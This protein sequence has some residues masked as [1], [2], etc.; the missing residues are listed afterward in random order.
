MDLFLSQAHTGSD[1]LASYK[2]QRAAAPRPSTR[3]VLGEEGVG[4]PCRI[5]FAHTVSGVA[6]SYFLVNPGAPSDRERMVL[7]SSLPDSFVYN[8]RDAVVTAEAPAWCPFNDLQL[9][10]FI[11]RRLEGAGLTDRSKIVNNPVKAAGEMCA[12]RYSGGSTPQNLVFPVGASEI[13]WI[14]VARGAARLGEVA[15]SAA[16]ATKRVPDLLEAPK[17]LS[18]KEALRRLRTWRSVHWVT[19]AS[20][21]A[22][23][24]RYE[25]FSV[26]CVLYNHEVAR[27]QLKA[28]HERCMVFLGDSFCRES[29]LL[30]DVARGGRASDFWTAA[31]AVVRYKCKHAAS[32][33]GAREGAATG[34]VENWT[35]KMA[36]VRS[37]RGRHPEAAL[38][39]TLEA[40][41]RDMDGI[42]EARREQVLD[43]VKV[44][45]TREQREAVYRGL[46]GR[47]VYPSALN[48]L[49]DS[50]LCGPARA[51]VWVALQA[52]LKQI[53]FTVLHLL[54]YEAQRVLMLKIFVPALMGLFLARGG[55]GG[56]FLNGVFNLECM[57]Q[58]AGGTTIRD[59]LARDSASSFNPVSGLASETGAVDPGQNGSDGHGIGLGLGSCS[60]GGGPPPR[61]YSQYDSASLCGKMGDCES[62][63]LAINVGVPL[64]RA[65]IKMNMVD[66]VVDYTV[67]TGMAK[68]RV[69]A[70]NRAYRRLAARRKRSAE[71]AAGL[72]LL[73][74]HKE[75][76]EDE[77]EDEKD[78]DEEGEQNGKPPAKRPRGSW[79]ERGAAAQ[80]M[81]PPVS[82]CPEPLCGGKAKE[83][84]GQ[85]ALATIH[86]EDRVINVESIQKLL[87]ARYTKKGKGGRYRDEAMAE[88]AIKYI[89]NLLD[90]VFRLREGSILNSIHCNARTGGGIYKAGP[91]PECNCPAAEGCANDCLGAARERDAA[92]AESKKVERPVNMGDAR[93]VAARFRELMM[94]PPSLADLDDAMA[95]EKVLQNEQLLVS[96]DVNPVF[97]AVLGARGGDLGRYVVLT[98]MVKF[99]NVAIA[100][101]V[102]GDIP[103]AVDSKTAVKKSLE[104]GRPRGLRRHTKVPSASGATVAERARNALKSKP[105]NYLEAG[106]CPQPHLKEVLLPD[107]ILKLKSIALQKGRGGRA[108]SRRQK[109]EHGF[110]KMLKYLFF[111]LDPEK[112]AESFMDPASAATLLRLDRICRD[113]KR[114]GTLH[115]YVDLLDPVLLGTREWV[116]EGEYSP[117]GGPDHASPV[118]FYT[119]LKNAMVDEGV[120]KSPAEMSG[121][122]ATD[123]ADT[124]LGSAADLF[125]ES[126]DVACESF[127]PPLFV[128]AELAT[129]GRRAGGESEGKG[130]SEGEGESKGEGEG[131]GESAAEIPAPPTPPAR[132]ETKGE[133]AAQRSRP[134]QPEGEAAPFSKDDG[135][136][137]RHELRYLDRLL[138]SYSRAS[139]DA[140]GA[141]HAKGG[142]SEPRGPDQTSPGVGRET[143]HLPRISHGDPL[144]RTQNDF[145]LFLEQFVDS[146][147]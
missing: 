15:A 142:D 46:G 33:E 136:A 66:H 99:M 53:N 25:P 128:P 76:E 139:V 84:I 102:D 73:R 28:R 21:S 85:F 92:S 51:G 141:G 147:V 78:S 130:E 3:S 74:E 4:E 48:N 126:R 19:E 71:S 120:V 42:C 72:A 114:H 87:T 134:K 143:G 121:R 118:D 1:L 81:K 117:E 59:I 103:S 9:H 94:D 116:A 83:I 77:D 113:R 64:H 45:M 96:L 55:L 34:D 80:G 89:M 52:L 129:E 124:S 22:G 69:A 132:R 37:A 14:T 122:R 146:L 47:T 38:E 17:S 131:E 107:C 91:S 106:Y 137:F 40:A 58:R 12:F 61:N 105:F 10:E 110:C 65:A 24:L 140:V 133:E 104:R 50:I 123:R 31:E 138:E 29:V 32:M 30:S 20:R 8:Y 63:P 13:N 127:R 111:S 18:G 70:E 88:V 100:C 36:R 56:V 11:F 44:C 26:G 145:K 95:A 90:G 2:T 35:D 75:E 49:A 16:D 144:P 6:S 41:V 108:A 115:W 39:A 86:N 62:I 135:K 119:L 79:A 93:E 82:D 68:Y 112:A 60:E 54:G 97:K 7:A 43:F 23:M 101:L 125:R 27:M 5:N 57:R 109:C 98:N 67:K